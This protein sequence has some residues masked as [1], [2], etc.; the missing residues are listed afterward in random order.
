M[1]FLSRE[2]C[3]L[4]TILPGLDAKLA[5]HPLDALEREG[6]PAIELFRAAGGPALLVPMEHGGRGASAVEAVR[7][8]RAIGSRSPSLAVASTMHHFS[9][10][11][12]VFLSRAGE[13]FEWMILEGIARNAQLVASGFAEGN[14]GQSILTP[15]MRA[16]R[17]NGGYV[18]SGVKKPCSLSRSMDLLTASVALPG[19]DGEPG[20]LAVALI[21]A[22]EPGLEVRPFWRSPVLAGAESDEV[23]VNEVEVPDQLLIRAG[24]GAGGELDDL[25]SATFVWFELLMTASYVGAASALAERALLAAKGDAGDRVAACC[26]LEMSMAAVEALAGAL[27]EGAGADDDAL[28]RALLVRYAAQSAVS[29]AATGAAEALGGMAFVSSSDVGYLLAASRA[30]AFHPPPRARMTGQLVD[31]LAGKPLKVA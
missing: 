15:T 13:G 17:R 16:G 12:L 9:V 28:A 25:Q 26:E 6:G 2:R 21:P 4:E 31:A 27:D 30:L 20:A 7:V 1:E 22:R 14:P 10:A 3:A 23:V 19:D 18:V 24:G 8:Q 29:R 5:E 11:S